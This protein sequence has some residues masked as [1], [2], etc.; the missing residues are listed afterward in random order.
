MQDQAEVWILAQ[1]SHFLH[2]H[3]FLVLN[4][5]GKLFLVEGTVNDTP[6]TVLQMFDFEWSG[7]SSFNEKT[8]QLLRD[9]EG[10]TFNKFEPFERW[11][12]DQV[13]YKSIVFWHIISTVFMPY[14]FI[15][16]RVIC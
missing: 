2:S 16:W 1:R 12:M 4:I 8:K 3:L 10:W 9:F 13:D 6:L 11:G 15:F 5:G 14:G 7:T